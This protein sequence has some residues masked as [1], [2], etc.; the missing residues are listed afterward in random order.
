[1]FRS[2]VSR[3][4]F[5]RHYEERRMLLLDVPKKYPIPN[6]VKH[7]RV[8]CV[9]EHA[10]R[11]RQIADGVCVGRFNIAG[12]ELDL[13]T[14]L[15]WLDNPLESDIEWQ[16]E[17]HKFYYGLDLAY[18]YSETLDPIYL[19]VWTRHVRSFI[20]QVSVEFGSSDVLARRIQNWIYA[21]QI[22]EESKN[23]AGFSSAFE[24]ELIA[25]IEAQ[26]EFLRNNLTAERNHRTLE[27]YALFIAALALPQ[28]D[29]TGTLLR[30]AMSGL[31]EN[32]M[33]DIR[34]DGTHREQSTHYHCTV[35]R[36]FVGAREN[37]RRFGLSFS[38]EF[39]ERL[40]KACE[41][42]MHIHRPDGQIPAFSDSDAGSYLDLLHLAGRI[43]SRPD[44]LFAASAGGEGKAPEI[45][46]ASFPDGGY[47]IQRS[48]WGTDKTSFSD[49]KFL[50]F[51]CGP[52]GDGGHGHYDLLSFELAAR[53]KPIIVD[54]GR[55][56]YSE[57]ADINWRH[58]FKGT[59]AHNTVVVDQKDQTGYRRGKPKGGLAEGEFIERISTADVDVICGRA[60]SPNYEA[61][62][63]RRIFFIRKKY[64]LIADE[65]TSDRRHRYDLRFH[66]TPAAWNHLAVLKTPTN[67]VAR[68]PDVA[69]I[70]EKDS[71]IKVE[72]GWFSP[73]YG[74]KHRIPCINVA[75]E[76]AST[77]F[78]SLI[79]PL[80]PKE[81]IPGVRVTRN[82]T[83]RRVEIVW[84]AA[85]PDI[86]SW[87]QSG[88]RLEDL[89]LN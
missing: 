25:S 77:E 3:L 15:N 80:C 57:G 4:C 44:F 61:V 51:D 36:S 7:R 52:I 46:N 84:E 5:S 55:F 32:L 39:D 83:E 66:L 9:I 8:F 35:L 31:T 2:V 50:M 38:Q 16:I 59:A 26:V 29:R 13:G 87:R 6:L 47:F 78:Y 14:D 34:P 58:F 54:C 76:A 43:F 40:L 82:G 11:N 68:T 64:W 89:T 85:G 70:F 12:V 22:F 23:S 73:S 33:T 65:M 45:S 10:Y 48:G 49:E 71:D 21:W 27:L 88:D 53:G 63:T 18:A 1:M 81:A 69:L 62:H 28:I 41:F 79:T 37:A 56:T 60:K 19:D 75:A 74:I 42:A 86:L 72:P 24:K 67:M 20:R 30:F 17:W